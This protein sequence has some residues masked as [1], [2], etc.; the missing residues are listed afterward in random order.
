MKIVFF[1]TPNFA[2]EV[3]DYLLLNGVEIPL[4]V[5]KPD[6]AKGRSGTP[7]P[8]PVKIVSEKW[9]I[10]CF[11]PL[12]VSEPSSATL[13]AAQNAD[14]FIVVAYGEI[15]KQ[16]ILEI[17]KKACINL[18]TS[19]LPNLR[20]AAPI[21]RAVMQGF[22][23]TGVT[24]M[25]MVKKMD[26]GDIIIQ[27]EVIIHPEETF[28]EIE[29]KLLIIGQQCLLQVIQ[30]FKTGIPE[31]KPQDESLVTFAPKI[32]LEECRIHWSSSAEE[33]HNLIRGANPEP[34]AFAKAIYKEQPISLKIWRSK[35]FPNIV[36]K[37][38]QPLNEKK[39]FIVPCGSGGGI[40]V[41]EL[42]SPGKKKLLVEEW[43]RGTNLE[44][45]KFI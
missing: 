41:L 14:L 18:H 1:G 43:L 29:K 42:Q 3:L 12:I 20:G 13:L 10:P 16:Q 44:Y 21:Q 35:V 45:L 28:G 11:Q 34:G 2:A 17:P 5:S 32:E 38:G 30:D 4:V 6:K 27:K 40:E 36:G 31:R 7:Q 39:S 22:T 19:L 24:V 8:T 15:L 25:H 37:I 33:V 9:K 26:A 23:R